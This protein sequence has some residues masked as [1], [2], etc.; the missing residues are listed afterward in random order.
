MAYI[1]FKKRTKIRMSDTDPLA[2]HGEIFF[3]FLVK[4]C[5]HNRT[6]STHC[7]SQKFYVCEGYYFECI[8]QCFLRFLFLILCS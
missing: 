1:W 3:T 7:D 8:T 2:V 6:H 5:V 4:I